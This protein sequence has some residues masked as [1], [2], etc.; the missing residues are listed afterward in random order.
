MK[1]QILSQLS[2]EYPWKEQ[3]H[4][5]PTIDSTNDEAK[6]LAIAGAPHGTVILA[7][8]QTNGHGRMGRS[9][10]SP[11]RQGIY[12]SILLRPN[13][14]P[15]E[16]MHLTCAAAVAMCDACEAAT[17]L[18]PGIKWT[19]D[20][21]HGK[22]KLGG[23]LT[24]MGL[25][26]AGRVDHCIIGI[27]IN[28]NQSAQ[29]FPPE[30]RDMAGSLSMITGKEPDPSRV[31]AAMMD[32]LHQMDARLLTEKE[33][34]LT[35]YRRD[36]ITLGKEIRLVRGTEARLGTALDIDAEGALVVRYTS[37]E[38]E[39]VNSGEVSI[40]GMYGYL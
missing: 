6:R 15:A 40:R 22:K 8:H 9:F 27:G 30:L 35:Q 31:A 25:T 16:L 26:A 36:C 32:A 19:N 39:I 33:A 21:V 17:G 29:D 18:R 10:H 20:L 7:S 38:T 37:G 1:H 28:C 34:I 11:S 4:Y 14:A 13:C 5:F 24:A 3:F 12:L 23:I 2:P